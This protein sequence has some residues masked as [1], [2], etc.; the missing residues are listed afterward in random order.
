M[1]KIKKIN[2]PNN[3]WQKQKHKN[4]SFSLYSLAGIMFFASGCIYLNS[5][6]SIH[7]TIVLATTVQPERYTELYFQDHA[8]LPSAVLP[9]VQYNFAFTIHNI[10]YQDMNYPY[11]VYVDD[12]N[13][14]K[15]TLDKNIVTLKKNA[16]ITIQEGFIL[17]DLTP[18]SQ[19]IVNLTNK[20][21]QIA[22]W[23]NNAS[24]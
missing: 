5:I 20:N 19:V 17:N 12:G 13:G 18:D 6:P 8:N 10:E 22:F 14:N 7:E 1:K 2:N 21:Q 15:Q 11:E 4:L 9:R 23:L 24:E 3:F 16:F